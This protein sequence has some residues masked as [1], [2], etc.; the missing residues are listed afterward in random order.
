MLLPVSYSIFFNFL[1]SPIFSGH[2]EMGKNKPS[3][4]RG[5]R[6]R[7]RPA[8]ATVSSANGL[9]AHLFCLWICIADLLRKKDRGTE[10][11]WNF[12]TFFKVV[13]MY[14]TLRMYASHHE[15]LVQVVSVHENKSS[16][17]VLHFPSP[18]MAPNIDNARRLPVAPSRRTSSPSQ[19]PA[20][21]S[22]WT[23]NL[24]SR[25]F[26]DRGFI[27]QRSWNVLIRFRF[28]LYTIA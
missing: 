18:T 15:G 10:S 22:Y 13:Y 28:E 24:S 25:R 2:R 4:G 3:R 23:Y 21:A 9:M 26:G 5:Q 19:V 6:N 14:L 12:L 8:T 16:H 1:W 17:F 7:T 11:E 20:R 27:V